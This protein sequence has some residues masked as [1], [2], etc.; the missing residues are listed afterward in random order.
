LS[1]KGLWLNLFPLSVI[2]LVTLNEYFAEESR[3]GCHAIVAVQFQVDL[4]GG[5]VNGDEQ[6]KFVLALRRRLYP[7]GASRYFYSDSGHGLGPSV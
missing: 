4:A 7:Q 5:A 1:G 6:I 2:T 3:G